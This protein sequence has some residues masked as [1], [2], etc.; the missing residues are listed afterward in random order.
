MAD[1]KVRIEVPEYEEEPPAPPTFREAIRFLHRKRVRLTAHFLV[2]ASVGVLGLALWLLLSPPDVEGRIV[3]SFRGIGSGEYPSGKKF[4]TEDFR[5]PRALVAALADAGIPPDRVDLKRLTANLTVIPIIPPE[6]VARWKK[7]DRDGAKRE[8]YQPNEFRLRLRL[9]GI[10]KDSAVR[11]FDAILKRY[12]EQVK[13]DREIALQFISDWQKKGYRDLIRNYDY[14][15]IPYILVENQGILTRSLKNLIEESAGYQDSLGLSFRDLQ[16]DLGI[17]SATRLEALRALTYKGRLVKN[18]GAALLTAQYR[19]E[20]LE[21][22][23]RALNDQTAEALRLVEVLQKPQAL[24]ATEDTGKQIP[25]VDASVMER[26]IRSDYLS[27]L[28]RKISELQEDRKDLEIRKNRL[29]KDVAYIAGAENVSPERLPQDYR[30]LV[31]TLSRELS[32]IIEKYNR[33]LDR[34]LTE[35][36]ANLVAVREGPRVTR[37]LSLPVVLAVILLLSA[38]LALF[39]VVFEHLYRSAMRPTGLAGERASAY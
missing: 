3:L 30:E 8:E 37:G 25:V 26:V 5:E 13:Y 33:L 36:V 23:S 14:W 9:A 7:Q 19:L 10:P 2:F 6:V 1:E 22:E 27:P 18:K 31:P 29:E 4:T 20:D 17:W 34:Y 15:E 12:R 35:T 28:V 16:K 32:E 39:S 21:I 38:V 11:L 24:L